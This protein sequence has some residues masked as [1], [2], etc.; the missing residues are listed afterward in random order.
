MVCIHD[1]VIFCTHLLALKV[2]VFY[3]VLSILA[4]DVYC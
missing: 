4:D 2:S 1:L 3:H